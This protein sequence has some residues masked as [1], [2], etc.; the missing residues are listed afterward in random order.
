VNP[1][2]IHPESVAKGWLFSFRAR[3]AGVS[4]ALLTFRIPRAH[5]RLP[6]SSSLKFVIPE[7]A[8]VYSAS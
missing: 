7:S 5:A 6:H 3:S 4:P 1:E 2:G 8:A